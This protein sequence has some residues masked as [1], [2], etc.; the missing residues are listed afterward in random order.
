M[1]LMIDSLNLQEIEKWAAI[2]PLAGVTSNPSI[3]KKEGAID[4]FE[5]AKKVRD[6][7][8]QE[9]SFHAQVVATDTKGI[10]KDAHKLRDELGGNL[11]VKVPVS[12]AGLTAIKELKKQGFQITATAIYTVFQGLLAIEAGADYLAPYYNRMEN[13]NTDSKEVIAQLAQAIQ[14]KGRSAKILAASFK[15]VHQMTEALA[16]GAE[17]VTVGADVLEAGF[18]NPSIQK[19]VDDFAADWKETQGRD[20]I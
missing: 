9:P 1:E 18:A 4:F 6:I 8:G 10:I 14:N 3:A 5:Q 7:I 2:L 15:N 16:A 13:L 17:A 19:A 11:Y 20:Y 12:K